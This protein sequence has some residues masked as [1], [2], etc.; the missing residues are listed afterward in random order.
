MT[1]Q[2]WSWGDEENSFPTREIEEWMFFTS[3]SDPNGESAVLMG[4]VEPQLARRI[5]EA[6]QLAKERGTPLKTRSDFVR[7]SCI[8]GLEAIVKHLQIDDEGL[9][10]YLILQHEAM[11]VAQATQSFSQVKGAVDQLCN[12]LQP[13]ISST[14]REWEAAK[15]RINAFLNPIMAMSG[16]Q[17]TLVRL[18]LRQLFTSGQFVKVM[19]RIEENTSLGSTIENARLAFERIQKGN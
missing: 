7:L 4:R 11:R 17:D 3:A 16:D 12:G 6:L 1:T 19:K 9:K 10:H 14:H 13:L 5:D 2:D 18:Y 15:Q 8:M